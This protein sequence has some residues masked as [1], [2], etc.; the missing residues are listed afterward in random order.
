MTVRFGENFKIEIYGSSHGPCVGLRMEGLPEGIRIDTDEL[1]AFLDRR[2]PGRN[3]WSTPRKEADRPDFISGVRPADDAPAGDRDCRADRSTPSGSG[4]LTNGVLITTGEPLVSEIRNTNTRPGDYANTAV[5]P[6]PAHADYPAWVKYGKIES[7]GGQFSARLTA[8]LCIAGGI[9]LEWLREQGIDITA[10]V[11]RIGDIEDAPFD[12]VREHRSTDM[13]GADF[14]VIDVGQGQKMKDLIE[15]IKASGDSIGGIIECM[16]TGLPPGLGS[17]LFGNIES[18]ICQTVFTV[19]AVKGI[20]FGAG[21]EVAGMKGSENNDPFTVSERHR[22][23][24][25]TNNHG[26]ILGGLS[27]GMPVIFRAAMKPTPSIA[28]PQRS[29]DLETMT[30]AQLQIRGRHDPCIVPRA[31]PCIEAAAAIAIADILLEDE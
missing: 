19:P 24:T 26:G 27:S 9:F 30:E 14:P 13:A 3:A 28:L 4:E 10:H 5:I 11:Y 29:V 31:V 22:V 6:R 1:Q 18:R 21:F 8:P 12:P 16:I 20:E 25:L 17:P 23:R 15:E 7:G 2:A